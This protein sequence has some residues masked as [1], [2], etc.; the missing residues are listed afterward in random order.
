MIKEILIVGLFGILITI[1]DGKLG[2]GIFGKKNTTSSN[3]P[4]NGGNQWLSEFGETI[5]KGLVDGVKKEMNFC[6]K[7]TH[8]QKITFGLCFVKGYSTTECPSCTTFSKVNIIKIDLKEQTITTSLTYKTSTG[9][10]VTK[11]MDKFWIPRVST[12]HLIHESTTVNLMR[13]NNS[14]MMY[15]E[16]GIYETACLMDFEDFPF[17]NQTCSIEVSSIFF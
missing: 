5:G 7:T 9:F 14:R 2:L 16:V 12:N 4:K 15:K 17:D 6:N 11:N 10:D 1:S 8:E 13:L 3:A